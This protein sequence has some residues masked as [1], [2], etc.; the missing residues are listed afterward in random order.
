MALL[1][2]L[3]RSLF[4]FSS[5]EEPEQ[6]KE[7]YSYETVTSVDDIKTLPIE[8]QYV[9]ACNAGMQEPLRMVMG[10]GKAI[11]V[12]KIIHTPPRLLDAVHNIAV[13]SQ[14]RLILSWLHPLLREGTLPR[15]TENDRVATSAL[16]IDL[17]EEVD[18]IRDQRLEFVKI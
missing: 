1:R 14:H 13:Y 9:I 2:K 18:I 7:I 15:F 12:R 6:A 4:S 16:G 17:D 5:K 11:T 10:N 3:S 8:L